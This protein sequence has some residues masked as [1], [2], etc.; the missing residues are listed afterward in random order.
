[1]RL[2][3]ASDS[4]GIFSSQLIHQSISPFSKVKSM[5]FDPKSCHK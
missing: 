4:T 3:L 5:A 2:M 1:M